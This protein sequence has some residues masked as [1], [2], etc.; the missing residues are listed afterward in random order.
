MSVSFVVLPARRVCDTMWVRLRHKKVQVPRVACAGT[1]YAEVRGQRRCP[2][3]AQRKGAASQVKLS[4]AD[5]QAE[6]GQA[7]GLVGGEG[8]K[9][10]SAQPSPALPTGTPSLCT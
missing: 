7:L 4:C 5:A 8:L 6:P 3:G 2:S 9:R 10:V 1:E